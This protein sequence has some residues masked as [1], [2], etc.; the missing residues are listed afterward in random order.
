MNE[1]VWRPDEAT[2][3]HANA[4]RLVA[5]AGAATT[6][7]L[8]RRSVEE[9]EWFWPLA[10][11]DMGL[12][13]ATPWTQV[14]DD[15]RGPGGRRGSS[16]AGLDR[17]QLRAPL[18]GAPPGRRR[19]RRPRRGRLAARADLRRAL[20]R[21]HAARRAAR[22]ARRRAGRPRRD[23]PADVAGGRDRLARDRAHRRDPGPGLLRLRGARSCTAARTRAKRR[24]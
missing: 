1:V 20:A 6:A 10:I 4:T 3:E 11:E 24:S 18:G 12:E 16:A 2:L 5:R 19:G 13:F 9:P 8:V 21:R 23:L 15:S 7:E 17:P 14:F 22:R